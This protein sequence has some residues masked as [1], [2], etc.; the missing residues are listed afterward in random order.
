MN[1]SDNKATIKNK[2][3][4]Y[5]LTNAK[6]F[7]TPDVVS[8]ATTYL[9]RSPGEDPLRAPPCGPQPEL[10]SIAASSGRPEEGRETPTPP[11]FAPPTSYQL[12]HQIQH[13]IYYKL[14]NQLYH[15]P[16]HLLHHNLHHQLHQQL[17]QKMQN[18][19][20]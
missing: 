14:N 20:H 16:R 13:Q 6:H 10:P 12:L 17:H 15:Q 1:K 9:G 3:K 2:P 7:Q 18:K 11:P 8:V 5:L 4:I 19:P